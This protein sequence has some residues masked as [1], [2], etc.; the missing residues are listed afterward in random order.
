MSASNTTEEENESPVYDVKNWSLSAFITAWAGNQNHSDWAKF[1]EAMAIEC[2]GVT[3]AV[4]PE[5]KLLA[6]LRTSSRHLRSL[7]Y[8]PPEH[9]VRPVP[10]TET[11][12]SVMEEIGESLGIVYDPTKDKRNK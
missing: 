2:E 4:I 8:T 9:P 6:R 5:L 11:L 1:H 12:L 3:G 7:G 10:D